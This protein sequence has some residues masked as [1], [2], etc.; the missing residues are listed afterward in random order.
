MRLL[1]GFICV[2]TGIILLLCSCASFN[3]PTQEMIAKM[4]GRRAGYYLAVEKPEIACQHSSLEQLI[5]KLD[6]V[7]QADVKDLLSLIKV[8]GPDSPAAAAAME[9]FKEG[10]K[11]GGC[12]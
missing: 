5:G 10:L 3:A 7:D 9:G 8:E 4:L 6:P 1:P 2:L 11:L 12:K